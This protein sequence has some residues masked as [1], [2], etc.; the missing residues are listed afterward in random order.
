[1]TREYISVHIICT[2]DL[3]DYPTQIEQETTHNNVVQT[4]VTVPAM[5]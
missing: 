1:M 5:M 3:Y 4:R 2:R